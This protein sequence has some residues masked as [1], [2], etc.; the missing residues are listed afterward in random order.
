[1]SASRGELDPR[2]A[3]VSL[4]PPPSCRRRALFIGP[5]KKSRDHVVTVMNLVAAATWR[6]PCEQHLVVAKSNSRAWLTRPPRRMSR[7]G[8]CPHLPK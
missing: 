3:Q 5:G 8:V 6:A 7:C 4:L 2:R 1:M